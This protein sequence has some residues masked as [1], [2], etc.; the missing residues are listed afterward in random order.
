MPGRRVLLIAVA[1]GLSACSLQ[2]FSCQ[3]PAADSVVG[4]PVEFSGPADPRAAD[5]VTVAFLGDSLTAGFGLLSDEAYPVRLQQM[6]QDDGFWEVEVLNGGV[7]GDTT[8]GGRRRVT[9]LIA[10]ASVRILV[11]ALGG[12]DAL[13]GLTVGQTKDNLAAIIEAAVGEGVEVLLVGMQAPTNLG[14]DYRD[15]FYGL[16]QELSL[17][18]SRSITFVPFLL[19]GV[20]GN[21]GLN[22]PDGIH[23]TAQGQQVI[24]DGLFPHL[25]SL[26]DAM[27]AGG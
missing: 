20:A 16:Y 25:R 14:S 7:S 11:V 22:Q 2:T 12:N 4:G 8:A 3:S 21:P 15:A 27:L 9:G 13:R 5:L 17:E 26:V 24:A 18:Y 19:E 23:P 1:C 6:L 10:D